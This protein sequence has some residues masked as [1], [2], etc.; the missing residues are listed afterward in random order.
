MSWA[1][2]KP[3]LAFIRLHKEAKAL[4][5]ATEG[6]VGLDISACI[7][8]PVV[9]YPGDAQIIPTGIAVRLPEGT[10]GFVYVRSSLG[11]KYDLDLSNSVGVI[12]T[13][14]RGE[15]KARIRNDGQVPRIIEPGQRILQM[16]VKKV[17]KPHV[18]EAFEM[19]DLGKTL[20]GTDGFGSTGK[21]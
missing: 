18:V 6:S 10:A 14:Y 21:F 20:R 13:D 11:F 12:D 9:I 2:P 3:S 19:S 4:A 5:Y 15:I 1:T 16:V 7:A 8:D 17:E